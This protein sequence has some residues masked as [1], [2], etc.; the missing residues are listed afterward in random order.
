MLDF[1]KQTQSEA[2]KFFSYF[3]FSF[4]KG[5]AEKLAVNCLYLFGILSLTLA[6]SSVNAAVQPVFGLSQG[7]TLLLDS[8]ANLTIG[9]KYIYQNVA[10]STDGVV[11]DAVV[12]IVDISNATVGG[13]VGTIDNTVGVDARFEPR[14]DT[15]A[16]GGFVEWEI[17]FVQDGTVTN[18]TDTG[19]R[20]TLDSFTLDAIDVDGQEFFEVAVTSSYTLESGSTPTELSVSSDGIY[21]RFQSGNASV[22]GIDVTRTEFVVRVNYQ[23]VSAI[24]FRTGSAVDSNNRMNSISFT[25]EVTFATEATTVLNVAPVVLSNTGNVSQI[26]TVFNVNLL[27]GASDA[28]GNIDLSTVVLI[29]PADA[30]NVGSVGTPL[31]VASVG[32]YTVDASGALSFT[33]V[34]SYTGSANIL[35]TVSDT[36]GV[37]SEQGTLSLNVNDPGSVAISG[38][39]NEGQTLTATVSDADGVSG[40]VA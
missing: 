27:T 32:T 15:S 22:S 3:F 40:T 37:S 17:V 2:D 38:T 1:I 8:N 6:A 10:T 12:T 7:P 20:A 34:S 23:N 14:V 5:I 29:D 28:D 33:P 26:D 9:A 16:P 19:E 18:A 36:L 4:F 31:V 13:G 21:T 39:V 30:S 24:K 35:F 11:V 25:G